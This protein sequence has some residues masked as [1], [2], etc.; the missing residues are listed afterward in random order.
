MRY[1]FRLQPNGQWEDVE[2]MAEVYGCLENL[3]YHVV[4][5]RVHPDD[6]DLDPRP[7]HRWSWRRTSNRGG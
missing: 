6:R 4:E 2:C 7:A 1:Q 5:M 3:P